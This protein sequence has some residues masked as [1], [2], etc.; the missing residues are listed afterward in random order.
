MEGLW[1][2]LRHWLRPFCGVSKRYFQDYVAALGWGYNRERV[3]KEE[4]WKIVS[5]LVDKE[6]FCCLPG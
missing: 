3:D 6:L 4:L 1:T 5:R 2:S